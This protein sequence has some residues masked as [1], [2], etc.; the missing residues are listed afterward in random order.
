M[1][2]DEF[3]AS[4]EVIMSMSPDGLRTS[5]MYW[6]ALV[7]TEENRFSKVCMIVV[8]AARFALEVLVPGLS[9]KDL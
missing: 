8:L 4:D 6:V 5:V 2:F 1:G 9:V 7:L 3:V